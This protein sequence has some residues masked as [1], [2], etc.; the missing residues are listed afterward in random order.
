MIILVFLFSFTQSLP[1]QAEILFQ[2][3]F[4]D[5]SLGTYTVDDVIAD[6]NDPDWT[7]GFGD[8]ES[9]AHRVSIIDGSEAY[10]GK[11]LRC[12]YPANTVDMD[13]WN[14]DSTNFPMHEM[15]EGIAF[16]KAGTGCS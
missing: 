8:G 15:M 6:W 10:E 14:Y 3:D 5:D 2:N 7:N 4:N 16:W 12:M 1:V 13:Q 11:S 9:G